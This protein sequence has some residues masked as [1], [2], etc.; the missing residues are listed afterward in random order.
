MPPD[1][2]VESVP[3]VPFSEVGNQQ[4]C[5]ASG[6]PTDSIDLWCGGMSES[7]LCE[8]FLPSHTFIMSRSKP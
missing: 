5:F 7:V 6:P 8:F 1:E 2:L 4:A 3:V